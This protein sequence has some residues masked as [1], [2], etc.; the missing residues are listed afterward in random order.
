MDNV[1]ETQANRP[2][3][4]DVLRADLDRLRKDVGALSQSARRKSNQRFEAGVGK[5]SERLRD[6]GG[7]I[8]ARPVTGILAAFGV[9][10]LLGKLVSR[11]H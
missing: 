8:Q 4:V 5:A 6:W 9:G 11:Q 2:S 7:E 1:S 10:L 3:E